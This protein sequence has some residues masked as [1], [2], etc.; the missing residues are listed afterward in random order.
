LNQ[1]SSQRSLKKDWQSVAE[2][3]R[4][5]YRL[6]LARQ[7]RN[8]SGDATCDY[9]Q[10]ERILESYKNLKRLLLGSFGFSSIAFVLGLSPEEHYS[11][12]TNAVTGLAELAEGNDLS[13]ELCETLLRSDA[14]QRMADRATSGEAA[15]NSPRTGCL[16]AGR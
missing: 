13:L 5:A 12:A 2:V 11:Q 6:W 3:E 16:R 4:L 15:L 1:R 10:A 9:Y 7:D 8:I 14:L